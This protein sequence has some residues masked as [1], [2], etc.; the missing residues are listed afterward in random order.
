MKLLSFA[1]L[2]VAASFISGVASE[3]PTIQE[4]DDNPVELGAVHWGRE[5]AAAQRRSQR[6][7]KPI[8]LLFQEI[9]GCS[10]CRNF[11]QQ[12]LSHPL[13]V[14]AIEDL[15]VPVVIYNN[16]PGEDARLLKQFGEP[17]WNN[18]VVRFINAENRDILPRRDG[19]WETQDLAQRMVGTL[20]KSKRKV[21][22]YLKQLTARPELQTATFAM[23]C[24]WEGEAKLGSIIGV[25]NT[26]SG[27]KNQLEVVQVEFDPTIV[28]YESLVAAAKTFDCAS[29]VYT[30]DKEQQKI[31]RSAVGSK[32]VSASTV[33]RDAKL[34]DQ[35]YYLRNSY[36]R[37][38]PLTE[39]QATKINGI[40]HTRGSDRRYRE[41]IMD[42]LSPRQQKLLLKIKRRLLADRSS[43]KE[44]V[45]PDNDQ[46]LAAYYSRLTRELDSK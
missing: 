36:L 34:S 5:L 13:M 27:W 21:P 33:I 30:H 41:M 29:K 6:T 42:V 35:A 26:R 11:G 10:T 31:A 8:F 23:H 1:V 16:K 7:G 2:I 3:S 4:T 46:K 17:S 12:P 32:A 14:E 18:P 45:W 37:H 44:F 24:Y 40:L 43:L 28:D 15:F 9:P 20:K 22:E 38:L 19:V 25:T 39:F